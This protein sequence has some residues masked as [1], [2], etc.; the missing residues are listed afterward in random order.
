MARVER[1][2]AEQEEREREE[3][4][5]AE[6]KEEELRRGRVRREHEYR[7]RPIE[8]DAPLEEEQDDEQ[9]RLPI[10]YTTNDPSPPRSEEPERRA[11]LVVKRR[12]L[13]RPAEL[14]VKRAAPRLHFHTLEKVVK[15]SLEMCQSHGKMRSL[16]CLRIVVN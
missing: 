16:S 15:P 11:L 10:G 8:N 13:A 5:L 7:R 3:R 1:E 4:E 9:L 2:R 14:L 12:D 6:R